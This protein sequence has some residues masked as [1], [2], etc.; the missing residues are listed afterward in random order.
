MTSDHQSN[1]LSSL[2]TSDFAAHVERLR[3][4]PENADA[5]LG[6]FFAQQSPIY[7]ARAPGRL[8]V[9]GGIGDYSGSLV[10][11]MPTAEAAFAAVQ[12][13]NDRDV[14][15][16]SLAQNASE[17]ARFAIISAKQM[18][19]FLQS[20]YDAVGGELRGNA[21]TAWTGYILGPVLTLLKEIGAQ[22]TGGLRILIDSQVPEGKGVS[23]SAA[24][25]VATMRA[26]AA[27]LKI[28]V[29]GDV[30]ARLCQLAENHVVGAPCGIMDQMT[31]ALGRE[32]QLLALRCQPANMEGFVPIPAELA[33]WGIDS[34]IRHAVSGSDYSSVRCGAFMGYRII[35]AAAGL[36]AK[37]ASDAP[38]VFEIDDP[39]WHGFLANV[40]P[41]EFHERFASIMPANISG[42][43]FLVRYGG[44]TDRATRIDP[45]RTYTVR[46]P[47][48]HPIEENARVERFRSLL[49]SPITEH[50]LTE[51]GQ[52][53]SASHASY[54][55]CGLASD[56]TDLL[57][58]LVQQAGPANGLYG[59]KITGGGSGGTIAILGRADAGPMVNRI[60]KQYAESTGRMAYVF[61]GSSPGAYGTPIVE[62]II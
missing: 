27:L 56:G 33:F 42:L 30:L 53:M 35:A 25:E 17:A 20:D 50:S 38:G 43:E 21:D 28:D 58:Q 59:A 10:L 12:R 61:R 34:G 54:T 4:L 19:Q 14:R 1:L 6:T 3:R 16:A 18:S 57:V 60:A 41:A 2:P 39:A 23:S 9:M 22:L 15:I 13:V 36:R 31:S 5:S 62:V 48:L 45:E 40:S 49:Q 55:A 29:S 7:V 8:D 32:H 11:E 47:T 46:A 44:T 24:I 51:M 52:L 37:P 26:I